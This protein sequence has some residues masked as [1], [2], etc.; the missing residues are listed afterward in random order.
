MFTRISSSVAGDANL[1]TKVQSTTR[2]DAGVPHTPLVGVLPSVAA[3]R[4]TAPTEVF[5]PRFLSAR[6]T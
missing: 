6:R 4:T 3:W 1:V 2:S 5:R